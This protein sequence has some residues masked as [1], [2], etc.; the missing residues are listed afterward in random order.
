M[1]S[2]HL[3]KEQTVKELADRLFG[4]AIRNIQT[5]GYLVP[6]Y[7]IVHPEG[8]VEMIPIE[9]FNADREKGA[10]AAMVRLYAAMAGAYAV[11]LISEANVVVSSTRGRSDRYE[12]V[13][14]HLSTPFGE[15]TLEA[16]F[17][18]MDGEVLSVGNV[19][20]KSGIVTGRQTNMVKKAG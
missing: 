8:G 11:L 15:Y 10:A 5:S 19:E 14:G 16:R 6:V 1:N 7:F 13:V 4:L 12:A 3:Q 20:W 17:T 9:R 18:R 2:H